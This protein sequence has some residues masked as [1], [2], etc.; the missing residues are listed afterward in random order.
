V[1]SATIWVG[2]GRFHVGLALLGAIL[3]LMDVMTAASLRFPTM[4]T[5]VPGGYQNWNGTISNRKIISI[6][7]MKQ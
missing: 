5:I 3:M 2:L 6:R 4:L 1:A 7:R